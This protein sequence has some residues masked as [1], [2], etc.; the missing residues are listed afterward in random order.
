MPKNNGPWIS[1]TSTS[2]GTTFLVIASGSSV[3]SS[4][5]YDH[6]LVVFIILFINKIAASDIRVW[7][8][9]FKSTSTVNAKVI[10][11]T[12]LSALGAFMMDLICFISDIFQAM[13]IKIPLRAASGTFTIKGAKSNINTRSQT[14]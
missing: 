9:K 13:T 6:V 7:I 3:S 14:E 11:S 4:S 1:Y 2:D 12:A 5:P 8:A 10:K